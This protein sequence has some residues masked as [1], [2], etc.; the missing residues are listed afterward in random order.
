MNA[1]EATFPSTP[2]M[3]CARHMNTDVEATAMERNLEK[4]LINGHWQ[5]SQS[6]LAFMDFYYRYIECTKVK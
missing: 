2:T 4:R 1:L 3:Q 6:D 5:Q